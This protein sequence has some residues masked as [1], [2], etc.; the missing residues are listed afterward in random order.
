MTT[1]QTA[2]NLVEF[3]ALARTILPTMSFDYIV[4]G[5]GDE[6]SLSANRRAFDRWAMVPRVLTGVRDVDLSTVILGQPVSM[7]VLLSP[8]A[9]Q[10]LAHEEGEI[11]SAEAARDAGTIYSL[12]TLSTRSIEDVGQATDAWWF[13]LYCFTDRAI[14]LDL[15]QR[16][17]S[18]GAK[19]IMVT[20]DTPLLGRR[21]ADE[22]N[23][24]SLPEGISMVNVMQSIKATLPNTEHGS[25]LAAFASSM[26]HS[27][28]TWADIEWIASQTKVPVGVKGVLAAK[29]GRLAVEH[30][31]KLVV[32]SN[33]GGRQLDHSIATLDALPRVTEAVD[34]AC[35]VLL[36]GGV[37]RGTDVLKALALGADAVMIGRPYVWG[38]TC[39]GRAGVTRVIELLRAELKLDM[40]L[41]GCGTIADVKRELITRTPPG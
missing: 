40:L 10:R 26:L 35:P 21:E 6:A 3:E 32:V 15:I 29:D 27:S 16:A 12:S 1:D 31:M 2:V 36:D 23:R 33:H 20:V 41:S 25:G 34:H 11:A 39:D 5:A 8:V 38:L 14:T 7:P 4:G 37:R 30:G 9:Y 28:L 24:F 19:A 17:E 18:A 13:Q 22:R